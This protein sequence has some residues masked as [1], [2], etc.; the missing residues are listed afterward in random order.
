[1]IRPSVVRP[2]DLHPTRGT[3]L[4]PQQHQL[5]DHGVAAGLREQLADLLGASCRGGSAARPCRAI[6]ASPSLPASDG[7]RSCVRSDGAASAA[8]KRAQRSVVRRRSPKV[9]SSGVLRGRARASASAVGSTV[10]VAQQ[11]AQ[12]LP[13]HRRAEVLVLGRRRCRRARSCSSSRPSISCACGLPATC[14]AAA[15]SA[16]RAG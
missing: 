2:A 9:S 1:M 10:L 5:P 12:H 15:S 16:R 3:E 8:E 14:G 6:P 11:V 13:R 7:R 4:L